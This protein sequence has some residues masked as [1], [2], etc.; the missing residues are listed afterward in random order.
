MILT[1][2]FTSYGNLHKCEVTG[3][4]KKINGKAGTGVL[5]GLCCLL[6]KL[7]KEII[8]IRSKQYSKTNMV[9]ILQLVG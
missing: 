5:M 7:L 2:H 6:V 4:E 1:I 3:T 9:E 8:L